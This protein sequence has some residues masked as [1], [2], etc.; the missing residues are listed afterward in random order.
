[1]VETHDDD[2]TRNAM[3]SEYRRDLLGRQLSNAV[4]HDK[5]I[6][7]LSTGALGLSIGFIKD[8]VPLKDAAAICLLILS[9]Y[10]F[11]VAIIGTVVSYQIGQKA[12][13]VQLGYAEKYYIDKENK[14]LKKRNPWSVAIMCIGMGSSAFFVIA[15]ILT[16]IFV[17]LNL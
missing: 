5:A 2:N 14:Y 16:V 12:I 17:S 4:Q 8:I 10:L 3:Y 13:N 11:A 1:M 7:S 9:W 15:A 6:L